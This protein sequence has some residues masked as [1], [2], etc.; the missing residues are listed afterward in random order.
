M[1]GIKFT[2]YIFGG[3]ALLVYLG[4]F[5]FKIHTGFQSA[6]NLIRGTEHAIKQSE[7]LG[8]QFIDTLVGCVLSVQE[9][10]NN[11][12]VF[13]P[14]SMAASDALLNALRIPRK[15]IVDNQA[16]KL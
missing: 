10:D 16:A 13:L 12:I 6:E 8:E 14:V 7:F 11:N 1:Q 5:P 4:D 2:L 3:F 15:V 9:I